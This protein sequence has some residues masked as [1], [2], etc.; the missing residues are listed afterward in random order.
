MGNSPKNKPTPLTSDAQQK[1]TVVAGRSSMPFEI[2]E[3]KRR[4]NRLS[5]RRSRARERVMIDVLQERVTTMKME[6]ADLKSENQRL[7]RLSSNAY[8]VLRGAIA[9][10]LGRS[11]SSQ[12]YPQISLGRDLR[13]VN[14]ASQTI[15]DQLHNVEVMRRNLITRLL[16][17]PSISEP[18]ELRQRGEVPVTPLSANQAYGNHDSQQAIL[19]QFVQLLNTAHSPLSGDN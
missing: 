1:P 13:I 7:L 15:L 5:A 9:S 19:L 14:P 8:A 6:Q 2:R 12:S 16:T 18:D 10:S 17:A 3:K 11:S 4:I